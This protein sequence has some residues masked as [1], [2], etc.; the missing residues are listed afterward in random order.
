M[1]CRRLLPGHLTSFHSEDDLSE[2]HRVALRNKAGWLYSKRPKPQTKHL[3]GMGTIWYPYHYMLA[4][5]PLDLR[6]MVSVGR[7][8]S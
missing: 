5:G 1:A 3:S 8:I 7:T 6:T 4:G 2:K